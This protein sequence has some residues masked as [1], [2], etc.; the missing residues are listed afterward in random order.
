MFGYG[1]P[2]RTFGSST[3]RWDFICDRVTSLYRCANQ[4]FQSAIPFTPKM[5]V[6]K[7]F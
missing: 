3:D 6:A 2:Q 4:F 7:A 1:P 5:D